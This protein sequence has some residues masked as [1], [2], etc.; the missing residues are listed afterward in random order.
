[1]KVVVSDGK[2]VLSCPTPHLQFKL[3]IKLQTG[4]S[5]SSMIWSKKK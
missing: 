1:M 2:N 3:M 4:V 5:E